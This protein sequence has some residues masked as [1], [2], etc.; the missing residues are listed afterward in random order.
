MQLNLVGPQKHKPGPFPGLAPA[1]SAWAGDCLRQGQRIIRTDERN[2]SV[3]DN[4]FGI[5]LHDE[6]VAE[7]PI[8]DLPY[9]LNIAAM[10]R[11]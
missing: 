7:I 1:H 4:L 11:I 10:V 9:L 3:P 5:I 8:G 2:L 6:A